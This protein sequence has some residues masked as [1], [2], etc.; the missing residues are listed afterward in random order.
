MS[1]W[2]HDKADDQLGAGR[3]ARLW[4]VLC[5]VIATLAVMLVACSPARDDDGFRVLLK[6]ADANPAVWPALSPMGADAM[7]D[8]GEP[9][10]LGCV[11]TGR[12][13]RL[14]LLFGGENRTHVFLVYRQGTI[15][16]RTML[17]VFELQG[18]KAVIVWHDDVSSYTGEGV[19]GLR[20]AIE[21]GVSLYRRRS[22]GALP[23]GGA[24]A[25]SGTTSNPV[26]LGVIEPQCEEDR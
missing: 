26:P 13:P 18:E 2:T 22:A 16:L 5:V 7:A 9:C 4:P 1:N 19:P 15:M 10:E 3:P 17:V 25:W 12:L 20:Q 23:V 24:S 11:I 14:C 8:P 6:K 21:E